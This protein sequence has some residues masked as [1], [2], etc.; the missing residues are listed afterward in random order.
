MYKGYPLQ[1]SAA[2]VA[3]WRNQTAALGV[4]VCAGLA[5]ALITARFGERSAYF[6]AMAVLACGVAFVMWTRKD[7]LR[8]IFLALTAALP[9]AAIAIPPGRFALTVFDAVMF[10]LTIGV[11][12]QRVNG[13][14]NALSLFPTRSLW[15]AWLLFLPCVALSRFPLTS[16]IATA[17]VCGLYTFFLLA[18]AEQRR[19]DGF[20]RLAVLFAAV[21]LIMALGIFVDYAFRVNLSL[22]EDSLNRLTYLGFTQI[23][24]PGGFFHDPQAAGA[25]IG[26]LVTFLL[27]LTLRGRFRGGRAGPFVWLAI[28]A[29]LAA[30]ALTLSRGAIVAC[31]AVSALALFMF[32]TWSAHIKAAMAGVLIIVVLLAAQSSPDVLLDQLP[33][34]LRARFLQSGEEAQQRLTVWFD[35][36][37]MFAKQP[38]TGIGPSSFRPY[39]L[40]TR[41]GV[42][43]YYGI[44]S[45]TNAG[46]VPDQPES[47]YL[48]ILYEGGVLGSLAALL[49]IADALRRALAVI[50]AR[51]A[52]PIARTDCIA[53]LAGLLTLGVTFVTLFNVS[54]P[55]IGALFA[56]LS[57]VIWH[58]S[59]E[60]RAGGRG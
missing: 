20:V 37:D 6:L 36:W 3:G 47:G 17:A 5:V 30:L 34:S 45:L 26:T 29:G 43:N 25:F 33:T 9:L 21:L 60:R 22:R 18:L 44:G 8:A 13:A 28:L 39:L 41:P 24:R 55:R 11:L 50:G 46:Y 40:A 19:R 14:E 49:L 59:L 58:R 4:A 32:N 57:A 2:G 52:D 35:T 54:E 38:V 16:V 12:W 51:F 7:T 31:L 48:K 53:A 1:Q 15:L 27:V 42:V 10:A 23:Y 56:F